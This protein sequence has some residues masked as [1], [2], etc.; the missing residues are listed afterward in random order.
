MPHS[1]RAVRLP[2]VEPRHHFIGLLLQHALV[3]SHNEEGEAQRR[4]GIGLGRVGQENSQG[5]AAGFGHLDNMP[6][7]LCHPGVGDIVHI[8]GN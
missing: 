2:S 4:E 7:R 8:I 5:P 1:M 3:G 6:D